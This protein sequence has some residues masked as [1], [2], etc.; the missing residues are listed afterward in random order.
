MSSPPEMQ[1][2]P[3]TESQPGAD[4]VAE[5]PGD[6]GGPAAVFTNAF[7][8][9]MTGPVARISLGE[10]VYGYDGVFARIATV[11]PV[12]VAVALAA[13]ILEVWERHKVNEAAARAKA[14][15]PGH[16]G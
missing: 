4:G 3:G 2:L 12:D 11:M 13:Q 10:K 9:V 14:E 5:S 7:H 16:G 6:T 15:K 8:V 1:K